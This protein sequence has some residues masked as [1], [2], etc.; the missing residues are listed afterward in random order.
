MMT[1][2]TVRDKSSDA[3]W[4][5]RWKILTGCIK[6]YTIKHYIRIESKRVLKVSSVEHRTGR[7]GGCYDKI[8]K[9]KYTLWAPILCSSKLYVFDSDSVSTRDQ[10]TWIETKSLNVYGLG[11]ATACAFC[12]GAWRVAELLYRSDQLKIGIY[13]LREPELEIS[14]GTLNFLL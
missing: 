11:L 7:L 5:L 1:Y 3:H 6:A 10:S 4:H 8:P 2:E 9:I 14:T 13:N 12:H